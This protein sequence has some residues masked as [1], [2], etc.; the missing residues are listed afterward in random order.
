MILFLIPS[1][2]GRM[3]I[4]VLHYQIPQTEQMSSLDNSSVS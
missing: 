3:E 4:E 2:M 1:L